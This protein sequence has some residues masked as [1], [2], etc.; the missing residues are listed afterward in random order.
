MR[1]KKALD[2]PTGMLGTVLH[3]LF[4]NGL[5]TQ[6]CE[7]E[8]VKRDDS[9]PGYDKYLSVA[10]VKVNVEYLAT[11]M[12]TTLINFTLLRKRH[13]WKVPNEWEVR[14]YAL[15][16]ML[17]AF[18]AGDPKNWTGRFS[19][20]YYGDELE[21]AILHPTVVQNLME[22]TANID[23]ATGSN[24]EWVFASLIAEYGYVLPVLQRRHLEWEV[25]TV[26]RSLITSPGDPCT[27]DRSISYARV[28]QYVDREMPVGLAMVWQDRPNRIRLLD[29]R[30]RYIASKKKGKVKVVVGIY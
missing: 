30:H 20:G 3:R 23:L 24:E 10:A 28:Q 19:A 18:G 12:I 8:I 16:R 15:E 21:K 25:R 5:P 22:A 11:D 14:L 9:E 1:K 27:Y 29:G 13:V 2:T 26:K 17:V 7:W 4:D 6:V